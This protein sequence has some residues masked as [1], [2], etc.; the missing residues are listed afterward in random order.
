[1]KTLYLSFIAAAAMLLLLPLSPLLAVSASSP[2]YTHFLYM[3]AHA[4]I[5]HAVL[6]A[7]AIVML[8]NIYSIKRLV[9][10]YTA[11][12]A[13]SFIP[14]EKPVTGFS[15]IIFFF[16]GFI[17][18]H[19]R[20]VNPLACWQSVAFLIIGFFLPQTAASYHLMAFIA[21]IAFFHIESLITS[22][23]NFYKR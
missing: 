22:Y 17:I 15:V 5:L 11:A 18:R 13:I 1:M 21:G 4:G 3:F 12:V 2:L 23:R 7:W 6:N 14:L 9:A 20:R 19:L 16:I 10:A 8:H